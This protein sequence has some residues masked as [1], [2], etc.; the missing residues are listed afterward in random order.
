MQWPVN[1]VKTNTFYHI[2]LSP[3]VLCGCSSKRKQNFSKMFRENFERKVNKN[4]TVSLPGHLCHRCCS[5]SWSR[6]TCTRPLD[7]PSLLYRRTP[8]Q[9]R[10]TLRV[11]AVVEEI[12]VGRERENDFLPQKHTREAEI[13][14]FWFC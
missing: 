1:Y 13:Y 9:K 12:Y 2:V 7:R 11:S 5:Q 4:S 10:K 14:I 6:I 8:A 3:V